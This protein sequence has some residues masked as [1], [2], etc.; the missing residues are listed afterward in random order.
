MDFLGSLGGS[1]GGRTE[2]AGATGIGGSGRGASGA[3][4]IFG[5]KIR[6]QNSTVLVV[7]GVLAAV[8]MLFL[9]TKD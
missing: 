2:V 5:D 7:V 4:T 8:A 9:F 3:A 6:G 1:G